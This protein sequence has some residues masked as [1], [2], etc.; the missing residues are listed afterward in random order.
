MKTARSIH[1]DLPARQA[2]RQPDR[3][4]GRWF[5]GKPKDQTDTQKETEKDPY[6]LISRLLKCLA[7]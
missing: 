2:D 7:I 3:L 1:I 6:I 4:I 5:R